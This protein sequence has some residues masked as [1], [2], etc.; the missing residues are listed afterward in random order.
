MRKSLQICPLYGGGWYLK[1]KYVNEP[2]GTTSSTP[3]QGVTRQSPE[4]Y[5]LART[6][7]KEHL[8]IQWDS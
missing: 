5:V 8:K 3:Y 2:V 1:I 4:D 7:I 6:E